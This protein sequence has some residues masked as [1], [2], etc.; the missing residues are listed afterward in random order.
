[1]PNNISFLLYARVSSQQQAAAGH[2]ERQVERLQAC[3]QER[4]I[5]V[6]EVI[7]DIGSGLNENR[8]G[9]QKLLKL[10]RERQMNQVLVEFKDRLTRF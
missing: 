3:A 2:L 5:Q 10:A 8:P 7:T 1:M 9:L 4:G 6:V